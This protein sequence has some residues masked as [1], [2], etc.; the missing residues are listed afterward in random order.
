VSRAVNGLDCI[1]VTRPGRWGNPYDVKVFGRELSLTLFRNSLNGI[2]D[3]SPL[4]HAT[5]ERLDKAY[6]AHSAFMKR[7]T[8]DHPLNAARSELCGNNL[9]CYCDLSDSCHADIYLDILYGGSDA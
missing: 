6:A 5:D 9:S 4:S 8:G 1:G 3:P 7:F 2:W